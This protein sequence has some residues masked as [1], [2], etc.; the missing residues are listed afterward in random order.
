[1]R[2]IDACNN[3]CTCN[4]HYTLHACIHTHI[5]KYKLRGG[6]RDA[7]ALHAL[8]YTYIYTCYTHTYTCIHTCENRNCEARM[9]ESDALDAL[10]FVTKNQ[11]NSDEG[12][13]S[14][15]ALMNLSSSEQVRM[16]MIEK[17]GTNT[18]CVPCGL[19]YAAFIM[20][21]AVC[22]VIYLVCVMCYMFLPYILRAVLSALC[23]VCV[24]F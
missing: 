4:T 1:V 10:L 24:T 9:L 16:Q 23:A 17:Q 7:G 2:V 11:R 14:M 6:M 12:L 19:L 22:I 5:R 15:K 3:T 21:Y 8:L 13:L 20:F 18:R